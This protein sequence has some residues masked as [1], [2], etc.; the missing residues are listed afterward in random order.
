VGQASDRLD[1]RPLA[2]N[3]ADLIRSY[4]D[5]AALF[6]GVLG[7]WGSGKTSFLTM[8]K[9]ALETHQYL[10]VA[11]LRPWLLGSTAE[12]LK[13]ALATIVS[14]SGERGGL[15]KRGVQA[16]RRFVAAVLRST[17]VSGSVG[18]EGG[19]ASAEIEVDL[20]LIMEDLEAGQG[21]QIEALKGDA[22]E[23]LAKSKRKT[24]LLVDDT[25]RLDAPEIRELLRILRAALDLPNVVF[26][27]AGEERILTHALE[28]TASGLDSADALAKFMQVVVPLPKPTLDQIRQLALANLE[29]LRGRLTSFDADFSLAEWEELKDDLDTYTIDMFRTPRDVVRW[30]NSCL[31]P[32]IHLNGEINRADICLLYAIR[33]QSPTAYSYLWEHR[34]TYLSLIGSSRRYFDRDSTPARRDEYIKGLV[35]A[36]GRAHPYA[37]SLVHRLLSRSLQGNNQE[38]LSDEQRLG[39][40]EY[41][42]IAFALTIGATGISDRTVAAVIAAISSGDVRGAIRIVKEALTLD[43]LVCL[44]SLNRSSVQRVRCPVGT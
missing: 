33:L 40:A 35:E 29:A 26:V 23:F 13:A 22:A 27:I 24:V 14:T 28:S 36:I 21:D 12:V 43:K 15:A 1:R 44:D 41:F 11:W 19:A 16:L 8:L 32:L 2:Q 4:E 10:S 30:A 9:E 17:K 42:A 20:G 3:L 34:D 18:G 37:E 7:P 38:R 25:D 5:D 6:V 39:S 31:L